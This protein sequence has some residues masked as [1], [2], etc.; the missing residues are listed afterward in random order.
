MG[1]GSS[2]ALEVFAPETLNL[3]NPFQR[4]AGQPKSQ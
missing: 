2:Q 4:R 3:G 1:A